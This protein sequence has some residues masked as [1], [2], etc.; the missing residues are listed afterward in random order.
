MFPV[1]VDAQ[2][3]RVSKYSLSW[4]IFLVFDYFWYNR[5]NIV[6]VFQYLR[7]KSMSWL[8]C[9]SSWLGGMVD[10]PSDL[11]ESVSLDRICVDNR[12]DNMNRQTSQWVWSWV[13]WEG[14]GLWVWSLT[15]LPSCSTLISLKVVWNSPI[16]SCFPFESQSQTV[17]W[18]RHRETTDKCRHSSS[19]SAAEKSI[20]WT[21]TVACRHAGKCHAEWLIRRC[22]WGGN[23]AVK[24]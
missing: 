4:R 18:N 22:W 5:C 24:Y 20:I 19:Q 16:K 1:E 10:L 9:S 23:G 14:V 7:S 12:F 2:T 8:S 15:C 3:S 6:S 13:I 11:I 17:H 21:H